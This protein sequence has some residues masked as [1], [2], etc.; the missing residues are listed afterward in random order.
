MQHVTSWVLKYL[1]GRGVWHRHLAVLLCSPDRLWYRRPTRVWRTAIWLLMVL[2][3]CRMLLAMPWH[4]LAAKLLLL[5]LLSRLSWLRELEVPGPGAAYL[6]PLHDSLR[7][8]QLCLLR[9]WR[10]LVLLSRLLL[11]QLDL[12][13][14]GLPLRVLRAGMLRLLRR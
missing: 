14:R 11:C 3:G 10:L 6:P 5:L 13:H 4:L 12:A 8:L 2:P 7:L 9:P 1:Q